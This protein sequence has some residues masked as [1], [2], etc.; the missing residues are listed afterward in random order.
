MNFRLFFAGASTLLSIFSYFPYIRNIFR[1]Q[2]KPHSFSWLIWTILQSTGVIVMFSSG[3]GWGAAS[4]A[5][6]AI[7]CTFVFFLSFR[8]GTHN[9]KFFDK[10]CLTGALIAIVIYV[11][12]HNPLLS[13][14]VVTATDLLGFLP[15]IRKAYEEPGTETASLYF[16]VTI[17]CALAIGAL[18]TITL[19]TSLYLSSLIITNAVCGFVIIYRRQKII[20]STAS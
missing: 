4:L 1:H 5:V 19:T 11:F 6:G 9:I 18:T 17:S 8:Y 3:A 14:I 12:L 2:T 20:R 15:T 16:I 10:V 7:L 13:V